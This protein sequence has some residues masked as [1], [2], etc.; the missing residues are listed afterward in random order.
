[1]HR[2][3]PLAPDRENF[4]HARALEFLAT[5]K[6]KEGTDIED[7]FTKFLRQE[8]KLSPEEI[9]RFVRMSFWKNFLFLIRFNAVLKSS[10]T[11][12]SSEYP[13]T[14]SNKSDKGACRL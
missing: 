3:L 10:I 5:E 14:A 11:D 6:T 2:G 13:E 9:L 4:I 12:Q 1:M 8:L 7:R